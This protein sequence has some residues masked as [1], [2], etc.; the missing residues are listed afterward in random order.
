MMG[1]IQ[2]E[3]ET[4]GYQ[5]DATRTR[6]PECVGPSSMYQPTTNLDFGQALAAMREGKVAGFGLDEIAY[7]IRDGSMLEV[8][9]FSFEKG[10]RVWGATSAINW[11]YIFRTDWRIVEEST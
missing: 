5:W 8:Y 10:R 6:C 9:G 4:C 11:K 1:Q 7:R 3:C 2:F